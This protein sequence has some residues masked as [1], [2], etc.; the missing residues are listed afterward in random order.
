[1]VGTMEQN[2]DVLLFFK[3]QKRMLEQL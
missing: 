2:C 1:M 3:P